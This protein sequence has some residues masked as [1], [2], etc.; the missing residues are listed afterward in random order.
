MNPADWLP[1]LALTVAAAVLSVMIA[2]ALPLEEK[3][4][5]LNNEDYKDEVIASPE[6]EDHLSDD[7]G[8]ISTALTINETSNTNAQSRKI[9]T[10]TVADLKPAG[11]TEIQAWKLSNKLKSHI[12]QL[13]H[14]MVYGDVQFEHVDFTRTE[15]KPADFIVVGSAGKIGDTY[16]ITARIVDVET[17]QIIGLADSQ[18]KGSFEE[19]INNVIPDMGDALFP[20]TGKEFTIHAVDGNQDGSFCTLAALNLEPK[21]MSVQEAEILSDILR[22]HIFQL[23]TSKD[24]RQ[25]KNRDQYIMVERTQMNKI[26]D[27]YYKSSDSSDKDFGEMLQVDRIVIGSFGKS[28]KTYSITARLVDVETGTTMNSYRKHKV[29]IDELLRTV[30]SEAAIELFDNEE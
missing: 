11:I 1:A 30:I 8:N 23:L 21:G 14:N 28:G 20:K 6:L 13:F 17:G 29:S 18:H 19:L 26:L 12:S 15:G 7:S 24:Y 16:S 5:I 4:K 2:L 25:Q 22:S 10:V 27:H 3:G 9:Y